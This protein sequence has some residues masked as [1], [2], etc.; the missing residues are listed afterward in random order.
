[1]PRDLYVY[2]PPGYDPAKAYPLV[3]YFHMGYIDEHALSAS[4]WI[5]EVDRM[6]ACGEFPPAIIACPDGTYSGQNRLRSAPSLYLN[7]CGGAVEDHV[8][9]EVIPFL[10]RTYSVRP[11]RGA[12]A[13]FGVSA[14]GMGAMSLAIRHRDFFAAIVTLAAP[15]NMRYSNVDDDNFE[16]F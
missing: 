13:L 14:G 11:E 6:M 2:L 3:L 1:M 16:D 4:R 10:T 12:H 9:R 7:G 5:G 15:L 8:M